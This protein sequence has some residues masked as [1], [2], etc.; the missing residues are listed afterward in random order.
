MAGVDIPTVQALMGHQSITMTMRYAHLSPE[1]KRDAVARLTK[2]ATGTATGTS[3]EEAK[4]AA[5]VGAQVVDAAEENSGR[6]WART[7]D[8]QLVR[9]SEPDDGNVE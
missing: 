5:R 9:G 8:P 1:H 7:S 4:T 3:P 6:Y 2:G